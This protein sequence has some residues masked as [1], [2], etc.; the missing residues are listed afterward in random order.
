MESQIDDLTVESTHPEPTLGSQPEIT[1]FDVRSTDP[2]EPEPAADEKPEPAKV[3]AD[4]DPETGKFTAKPK[5]GSLDRLIW[6][7]EEAERKAKA[8]DDRA[9]AAERRAQ[10]LEA[11][12]AAPKPAEKLAETP[13]ADPSVGKFVYPAYDAWA[14]QAENDG[15]TYEDY[16]DDRAEAR[17][18]FREQAKAGKQAH[19]TEIAAFQTAAQAHEA[20]VATFQ[21]AH[22]DLPEKLQ[23]VNAAL[24]AVGLAGDKF[25]RVL[26]KALMTSDRSA[27][28]LYDLATHHEA[29][30]QLAREA[31]EL[32]LTAAP[33][34]RRLL[35]SRLSAAPS[36]PADT[37]KLVKPAKEPP[38]KP[39]V[40]SS[41]PTGDEPPDDDAPYEQHAAYW[42]KKDREGRRR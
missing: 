36:G 25:P 3:A 38:I 16:L 4:R 1:D 8:A 10:E 17:I 42:D 35:E 21:Q 18:E 32:P 6:E 30:I 20:R 5:K 2:D 28:I 19:E 7:R 29:C 23:T 24:A 15:R 9:A 14:A 27:E 22:P 13:K 11:R 31:S 34:M 41:L 39:V 33:M 40:G 26:T 12:H 37:P